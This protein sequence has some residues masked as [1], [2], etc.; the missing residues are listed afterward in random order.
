VKLIFRESF[1]KDLRAIND[2]DLLARVRAVIELLEDAVDLRNVRQIR[3]LRESGNSWE[4]R[5][6]TPPFCR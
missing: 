4:R 3:K 5:F 6:E 2:E 1:A